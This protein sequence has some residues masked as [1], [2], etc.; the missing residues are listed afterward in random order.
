[1]DP[2]YNRLKDLAQSSPEEFEKER[3]TIINEL[4]Q[5]HHNASRA[6]GS[7]WRIDMETTKAKTS[8]GACVRL[9]S[10]MWDEFYKLEDE[11]HRLLREIKLAKAIPVLRENKT[12]DKT[13]TII[14]FIR[15]DSTNA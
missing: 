3:I 2:D 7:Q 13:A 15:N 8:L 12:S 1:M 14:P 4:I 11:L 10:L 6:Q 9:S 5:L